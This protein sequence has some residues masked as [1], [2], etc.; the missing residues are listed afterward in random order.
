M[1]EHET[2]ISVR[3][4]FMRLGDLEMTVRMDG[5]VMIMKSDGQRLELDSAYA[6]VLAGLMR[7]VSR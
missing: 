7:M 1:S 2:L 4:L 5:S 6:E 3:G